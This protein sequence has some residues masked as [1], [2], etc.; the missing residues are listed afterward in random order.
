MEE[1]E[2][3]G[4]PPLQFDTRVIGRY[5]DASV[6]A[7]LRQFHQAKGFDP[8]SQEVAIHLGQP[9]FRLS[10][11]VSPPFAHVDDLFDE[12]PDEEEDQEHGEIPSANHDTHEEDEECDFCAH[13]T[14]K[15]HQEPNGGGGNS[16]S[17]NQEMHINSHAS[18]ER[19]TGGGLIRRFLA[20]LQ[21]GLV[22]E[23]E[24][25]VDTDPISPFL[26]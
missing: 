8:N 16:S 14:A 23:T 13:S 22:I 15:V 21:Q 26:I 18:N 10:R 24:N 3:L 4:F 12:R 5:C 6:Y 1:A 11:D 19:T 7:G 25:N 20:Q 2:H 17:M 9:L